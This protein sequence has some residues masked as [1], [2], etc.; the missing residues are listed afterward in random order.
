MQED[1]QS[2]IPKFLPKL[3]VLLVTVIESNCDD[4]ASLS[5]AQLKSLFKIAL[6]AIRRAQR[7]DMIDA[8]DTSAWVALRTKLGCK[9][10]PALLKMCDQII[11][12]GKRDT[13]ESKTKR[14]LESANAE[15]DSTGPSAKKKKKLDKS[16]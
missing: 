2:D 14:K 8:W 6:T 12:V 5:A 16:S 1:T 7:R 3:N 11:H 4:K 15:D 10:S 9:S 13:K